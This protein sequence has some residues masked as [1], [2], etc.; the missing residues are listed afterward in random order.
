MGVLLVDPRS[1]DATLQAGPAGDL[2]RMRLQ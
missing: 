1:I 2:H